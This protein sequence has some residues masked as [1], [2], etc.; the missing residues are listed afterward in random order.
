MSVAILGWASN[1]KPVIARYGGEW[2]YYA[3][4]GGRVAQLRNATAYDW[5]KE[6]NRFAAAAR[7]HAALV[8][9][10]RRFG[11]PVPQPYNPENWQQLTSKELGYGPFN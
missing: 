7:A 8:R 10:A 3:A 4:V 2:A 9:E 5:C 6:R 11:C 1:D